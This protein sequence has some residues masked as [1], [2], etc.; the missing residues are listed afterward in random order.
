MTDTIQRRFTGTQTLYGTAHFTNLQNAHA[1]VIGIGGVGSW[2]AEALAR[3][4]VGH[5]TLIDLDVVSESN[6]NR[7]LI[8][9]NDTLGESKITVMAKRIHAINPACTFTLVDDFLTT[10]NIGTLL[11]HKDDPLRAFS[12]VFDCTDDIH[13][14]TA[15]ALHCRFN[16]LKLIIAG[17]AGGKTDPSRLSVSDLNHTHQDPLLAKLRNNLRKQ[18]VNSA[19]KE[20]F[21]LTC[22]YSQEPTK[23]A[24]NGAQKLACGGYG[25]AVVV[26]CTMAMLMVAEGLVRL[27]PARMPQ[28]NT[29]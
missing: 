23:T 26:T 29:P 4:G 20:K 1:I 9:C 7:Q 15:I 21:A 5:L 13:A 8:A 24:T 28:K 11:P 22:V 10:D 3:T 18:G 16:K 17:S 27:H 12:V 19:R 6:I 14:K 2:A 25:S